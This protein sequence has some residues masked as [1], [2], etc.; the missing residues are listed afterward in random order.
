M[1]WDTFTQENP[2]AHF[3]ENTHDGEVI[4]R[5]AIVE[6]DSL[7]TTHTFSSDGSL[8]GDPVVLDIE[9]RG[10]NTIY[11]TTML[12][13]LP[14]EKGRK[15]GIVLETLANLTDEQLNATLVRLTGTT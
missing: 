2:D 7:S 4:S 10:S 1:D 13:S 8:I 5:I 11:L 6:S 3:V 14:Y 15:I 9:P 12:D